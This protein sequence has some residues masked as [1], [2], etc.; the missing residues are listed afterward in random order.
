MKTFIERLRQFTILKVFTIYLR[1]LIGGGFIMPGMTKMMGNRFTTLSTET[2]VGAF[3]EALYQTGMYWQFLGWGQF[4][5]AILLM[6][7]RFATIGAMLFFGIILNIY[8]ITISIEFTGT[9]FITF[10]MLLAAIYLLLWDYKKIIVLFQR[11]DQIQVNYSEDKDEFLYHPWWIVL[12]VL[13]FGIT[14]FYALSKMSRTL[15]GL[16][17][18]LEWMLVCVLVGF[19]GLVL[20]LWTKRKMI[21]NSH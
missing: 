20:F 16:A 2:D 12:G 10:P 3:F 18:F 14:L 15:T 21:F 1:Y 6:T 7:Q 19:F 13:L 11:A 17:G 8:I 5:A 9:A 4:I